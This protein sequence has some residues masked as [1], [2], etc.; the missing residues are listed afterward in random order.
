[1]AG[2]QLERQGG[3]AV[4]VV[5]GPVHRHHDVGARPDHLRDPC[6]EDVPRLDPGIAQQ[7]VDLFDRMLGEKAARLGEDLPMSATPS[8]APVMTPSVAFARE[9]TA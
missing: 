6:G 5:V 9:S 2:H 3:L 7:P 8:D 1:M 4:G